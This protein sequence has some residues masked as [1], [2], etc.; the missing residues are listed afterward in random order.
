M[1]IKPNKLKL[2]N[3]SWSYLIWLHLAQ[4]G[5]FFCDAS[6]IFLIKFGK[7]L[8]GRTV[9]Q[10]LKHMD[11]VSTCLHLETT[12]TVGLYKL[13]VSTLELIHFQSELKKTPS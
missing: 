6:S 13:F 4:S 1:N 9:T 12:A 7:V 3:H 10:F 11:G 5:L 2:E 8:V